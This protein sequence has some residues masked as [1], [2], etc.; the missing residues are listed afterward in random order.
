MPENSQWPYISSI[1]TDDGAEGFEQL[2]W[3]DKVD[4]L[5]LGCLHI[6]QDNLHHRLSSMMYFIVLRMITMVCCMINCV[7]ENWNVALCFWLFLCVK[8]IFFDNNFWRN[9]I[10]WCS[11]LH[12]V[13][14]R[15]QAKHLSTSWN[16]SLWFPHASVWS[17]Q[18]HYSSRAYTQNLHIMGIFAWI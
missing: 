4:Q 9:D 2:Y 5:C 6:V 1:V 10:P 15:A 13:V 7:W 12:V 17:M 16:S 3:A 8:K 18:K 11:V 14:N